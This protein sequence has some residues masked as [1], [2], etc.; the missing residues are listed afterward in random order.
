MDDI[1]RIVMLRRPRKDG[2]E[3]RSDPFWEF[4]SFGITGCHANNIMH[5]KR[6]KELEGT[7][8]AFAQGGPDASK[9]R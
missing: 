3:M 2:K 1:I 5:P 7:R 6:C 9:K 4:G 8:L